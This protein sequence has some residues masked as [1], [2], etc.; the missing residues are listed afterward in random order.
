MA[1]SHQPLNFKV[2]LADNPSSPPRFSVEVINSDGKTLPAADPKAIRMLVALMD[3]Q[4]VMGGAASHWGGPSAFAELN[5]AL[6]ALVFEKAINQGQQWHRLFH[7]INDAGHCENGLYALKALYGF[8]DLSLEDLK[9]FRSI[10]SPLTGHGESHLF[11]EGVLLSNGPLGSSFP[12]AQGLCM[13]DRVMGS[14]RTTVTLISDGACM[15]GEAK[16]ALAAIP[17]LAENGRM[18]PFVLIISDNNTKLTGRIDKDSFS[19]SPTFASLRD[20]GWD[21]MTLEEGHNL[22]ACV[23]AIEEALKRASAHPTRPVAIHAKTIKG[24]GVKKTA[25]SNSGGHGFPLKEPKELR[26]FL[27][28][29][30]GSE[31]LP[32][33]FEAWLEDMEKAGEEKAAKAAQAPAKPKDEKVS[34]KVQTGV[35]K[36]M[37][38]KRKDGL[39][40]VSVSSDLPGS[41]GVAD[42]QKAYPEATFDIGVA[43]ANMVSV[44]AGF[45]KSGYIP[46]VDTFSQFGVT[47]GGLPLTMAALS[48]APVIA[49][50]SHAGFQD[51]ADGAS[52]QAL[53][54]FAQV[55]AIPHTDVYCLSTSEEAEVLVGQAI[56]SF[57]LARKKGEVPRSKIFFLGRE[58]FPQSLFANPPHYQLGKGQLVFEKV[59]PGKTITLVGAGPLL[60]QALAAAKALTAEGFG[61]LVVNPSQINRPDVQ[62]LG[63]CLKKSEGKMVTVEDH[64]LIGG[65]GAQISHALLLEGHALKL[66]SLG[67][68]D[69]FGQSAYKALELYEKHGLDATGIVNAAKELLSS[70]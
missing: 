36:A 48:E 70:Q 8:A 37:I 60:H 47:K 54:Y 61:A 5:S 16:E 15:E 53:S 9:G 63:E 46:I 59:V 12:Q 34:E 6:H 24:Y 29:V 44:A 3:M 67:V 23:D 65:M 28:E 50:F 57:V 11:P 32:G 55:G 35:S 18:N 7:I 22:Q 38:Q 56:E 2:L 27:N 41:T 1:S 51:A 69:E 17:G 26:A 49:V 10:H 39:P 31:N 40:V 68:R 19:M 58:N 43:E 52:H 30:W 20:L 33:D 14:Q 45:S 25:E 62:L 13:A 42:F 21:V 64:Q 66:K 4:A